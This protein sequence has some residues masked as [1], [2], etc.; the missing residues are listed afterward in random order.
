MGFFDVNFLF[1]RIFHTVE[2]FGTSIFLLFVTNPLSIKYPSSK[3]LGLRRI[4]FS[5]SLSFLLYCLKVK[6]SIVAP[7]REI[8]PII[9]SFSNFTLSFSVS[10]SP[11][12]NFIKSS[13]LSRLGASEVFCIWFFSVKFF[14]TTS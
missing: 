14:F 13:F 10:P 3:F 1:P 8:D 12:V 5:L 2:E 4:T 11:L 6:S 7:T 9:L